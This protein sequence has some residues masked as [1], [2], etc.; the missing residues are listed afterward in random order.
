[1]TFCRTSTYALAVLFAINAM[2]FFDRMILGAVT[3]P[4][5]KEW[6]LSDTAIGWLGTAFT[7]IYAAVGLPIGALADRASRK[8]I[9][10]I[11]VFVW[12]LLTAASGLSRSFWQL[13]VYRL[14][15]GI[16]EAA[17]AP[18]ATS[19]IGDLYPSAK[20]SRAL[21]IFMMGLPIGIALS[22]LVSTQVAHDYGWRA[23]FYVAGLPGILC[24]LA[25]LFINEPSRGA[26]E[27]HVIGARR[28]AGHPFLLVLSIPTMWWIIL[29]GALFNFIMYAIGSFLAPYLMRFHGSGIREAGFIAMLVYGLSGLPALALGGLIGDRVAHARPNGRMLF[30]AWALLLSVP[31]LYFALDAP[32][33]EKLL[34]TLLMGS[35]CAILYA[36]YSLVYPAIQDVIEPSLRGT[37]MAIYFFA[38]YVLGASLGP[39]GTGAASTFF[40][41][42]AALL[43]GVELLTAESLEPFRAEGL[44][45]AMHIIPILGGLLALVLFA[46]ARTVASDK[47]RLQEW[48]RSCAAEELVPEGAEA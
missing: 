21:S 30:A 22:F 32:R 12:S 3:E 41:E 19:L 26:S 47:E 29:S 5:R 4:I 16:G 35:G 31:L 40:T 44:R 7:L 36:Y 46:G 9:L 23:A 39:V 38:M 15:V 6:Q 43:A 10:G 17:C 25:A 1:M 2:N 45:V 24:G 33:G 37:A 42:R 34:F 28:R 11:G 18:A 48:M 13:F 14:G 8:T 27:R 20:R